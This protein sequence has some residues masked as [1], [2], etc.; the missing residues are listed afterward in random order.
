MTLRVDVQTDLPQPPDPSLFALVRR[1]CRLAAEHE[2][3]SGHAEYACLLT[4][5]DHLRRLNREFKKSDRPTDV[6]AFPRN[7]IEPGGD[8][9]IAMDIAGEAAARAG[10]S[11]EREVAYLAVHAALH[12]L[13]HDHKR[14]EPYR[15]MRAAEEDILSALGLPEPIESERT[16]P[17]P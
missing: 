5:G 16:V 14:K 6:L 9:A 1:A 12:L 2:G 10:H 17:S 15:R 4:S 7:E 13:G 8:V 11:L 3:A